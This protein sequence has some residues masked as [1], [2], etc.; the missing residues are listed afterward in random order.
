M[1]DTDTVARLGGDEFVIMLSLPDDST[2]VER[3][4]NQVLQ[5]LE[6]AF[7]LQGEVAYVSA[8]IGITLYPDDATR[9]ED[10]FKNAD[11]AM[12]AAKNQGRNRYSY[13]TPHMQHAAQL[14]MQIATDLR[15]AL[16]ARAA[17]VGYLGVG[18]VGREH[19]NNPP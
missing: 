16:G 11:Q 4:A 5:K 14:R 15:G 6:D 1:R 19:Q 3:V 12:Y 10:L 9:I 18:E 17:D 13:F 7:H 2:H 8:S